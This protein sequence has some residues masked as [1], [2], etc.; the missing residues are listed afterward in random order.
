LILKIRFFKIKAEMV[1]VSPP[2]LV[3]KMEGKIPVCFV[4]SCFGELFYQPIKAI[5]YGEMGKWG[6]PFP[7]ET[8]YHPIL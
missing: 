1:L 7:S 2:K 8:V 5:F 3:K 6:N 4:V